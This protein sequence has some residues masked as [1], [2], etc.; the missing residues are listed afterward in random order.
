MPSIVKIFVS[1]TL[2]PAPITLQ[3]KGAIISQ[4]ATTQAVNTL[5][6][7]TQD[8]D[9]TPI[10]AAPLS[11][12]SLSWSSGTVTAVTTVV[13]PGRSTGDKFITTI[14]GATPTGFNGL[15]RATVTGA[16]TF[17]Y[18]LA[19]NPGAMTVAGT[20]TPPGQGELVAQIDTFYGQGSSQAVYVLELGAGD[21]TNGPGQLATWAQI[22]P[23]TIYSYLIPRGWDASAG[24]LALMAQYEN[25]TAKTYFW[26]TSTTATYTAYSAT[27]KCG[28]VEIEAP[29][30]P[31][32]EFSVATAFQHSLSYNPST[33][34]RVTPFA[35]S[36]L[37]GVTPYPTMGNAALLTTLQGANINVVGTGA[38]GG[39]ST[40]IQLW[41]KMLDGNDFTYWYSVDWIQLN[42]DR[43]ISN[44]VINGSNDPLNPLYYDQ[45]GINRLQDV[46][47]NTINTAITYGLANG[48]AAR[49]A[50][51]GPV[52]AQ[53]LDDG[54]YQDQDVVNAI[55]F[56]T[57]TDENPD[58]YQAGL[59]GGLSAVYIPQR[60]FTEII[61]NINVT[62]F[63]AQ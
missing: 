12:S 8:V 9:L 61:F 38:E 48:T 6:L 28:F 22:N 57:Y 59:Y 26:I 45:N 40:A 4:G 2:A 1:Q 62:S 13:I 43:N 30:T 53:A 33:A 52:F 34:N 14:A 23:N 29:G 10:L 56:I 54:V 15:V 18:A 51:D 35:Y 37:F 7:L 47:V 39:I 17:T 58:D 46:A 3:S 20:Y 31:L 5:S 21:Q 19:S 36:Y 24:L 27:Q 63:L 55:P 41:G 44:A 16:S 42:I 60:G 25:L 32:T 11:L 50:L 49:A